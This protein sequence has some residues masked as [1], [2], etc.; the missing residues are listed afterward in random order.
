MYKKHHPSGT[1]FRNIAHLQQMVY[2]KR[3][4]KFDLGPDENVYRYEEEEPPSYNLSRLDASFIALIYSKRD[5]YANLKDVEQLKQEIQG[6]F[7][8]FE[9]RIKIILELIKILV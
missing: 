8:N 9:K 6:L 2:N 7:F 3:F 5:L 4:E 1:S